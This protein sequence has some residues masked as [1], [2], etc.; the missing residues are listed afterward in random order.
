MSAM[1]AVRKILERAT[2]TCAV[3]KLGATVL[4][5][6][7]SI[8]KSITGDFARDVSCHPKAVGASFAISETCFTT[9]HASGNAGLPSALNR[10]GS[11][12]SNG[13]NQK[14]SSLSRSQ[15]K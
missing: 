4:C 9:T 6:A 14:M 1:V 10:R 11:A 15:S 12:L 7:S 2:V 8:S 3:C 5:G 13:W